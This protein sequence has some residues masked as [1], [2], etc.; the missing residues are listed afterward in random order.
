MKVSDNIGKI[1]LNCSYCM[2]ASANGHEENYG[3]CTNE[4][5]FE[6]YLDDIF[7]HQD[8]SGC[9]SLIES[10]KFLYDKVA[11]NA[12]ESSEVLEIDDEEDDE[13]ELAISLK[14]M[15]KNGRIDLDELH[16]S[17]HTSMRQTYFL[18]FFIRH[19]LVLILLLILKMSFPSADIFLVGQKGSYGSQSERFP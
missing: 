18:V 16:H 2:P 6:P 3:I 10:K 12:F 17:N 1:C 7:E 15:S 9:T 5:E 11:C 8:Y 13:S 14:K 4:E 19:Q